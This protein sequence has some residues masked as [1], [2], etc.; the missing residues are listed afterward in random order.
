VETVEQT[1]DRSLDL[2]VFAGNRRGSASTSDF[3]V[4]ALRETVEAAWHIARY[5]AED[6]AAGLPETSELAIDHPNLQLPHPWNISAED[7]ARMAICGERAGGQVSQLGTNTDGATIDTYEGHCVLGNSRGFMGGYSY[8]RQSLSVA[9][10]A[11]RGASMHRDY[12]Y[13]TA[14]NAQNL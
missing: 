12:W 2:T 13:T 5:T 8:S 10:I 11:G 6:P 4:R 9:P 7:S 3:S 14:R 1:R